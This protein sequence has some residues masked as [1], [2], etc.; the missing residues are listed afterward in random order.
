MFNLFLFI[1]FSF[2]CSFFHFW[3]CSNCILFAISLGLQ[4]YILPLLF[5]ALSRLCPLRE[6]RYDIEK[7]CENNPSKYS[8]SCVFS[9][10]RFERYDGAVTLKIHALVCIYFELVG[11]W[12]PCSWACPFVLLLFFSFV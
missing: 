9:V 11:D 2:L 5:F 7:L 12:S 1:F 4:V 6:T 8:S 3:R 10:I